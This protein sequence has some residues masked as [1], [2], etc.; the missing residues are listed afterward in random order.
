M[1]CRSDHL[2]TI[3]G[4]LFPALVAA[5]AISKANATEPRK[6][7]LMRCART[8]KGVSAA[9]NVVSLKL[10]V[11]DPDVVKKVNEHLSPQIRVWNIQVTNQGFNGHKAC[12]SRIYE[13]LIPTFSLLP[14]H[15]STY[16]GKKIAEYAEKEGDVEAHAARQEEVATYWKDV[17]ETYIKPIL[18]DTPEEIREIVE[19]ALWRSDNLEIVRAEE[20]GDQE[21]PQPTTTDESNPE[22]PRKP[23]LPPD[24]ARSHPRCDEILETI[25]K[26]KAAHLSAKRA[27]R[28]PSS[29]FNRFQSAL[30]KYVGTHNFFNY[31]IQ[32]RHDE[33]SSK[34]HIKSFN[35][36]P[37][38]VYVGGIEWLS[39]KVHGQS[40]MMH[41]IRKMVSMAVQVVRCGCDPVR[42]DESFGPTRIGIPKAP[43]LGLLL[44]RPIFD[45]FNKRIMKLGKEP[46]TF[47]KFEKDIDEFKHREIYTRIFKE[48][49]ES[50]P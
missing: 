24:V 3:E 42:I 45:G 12:D 27:Y 32:K 44:E 20:A 43:G 9:G 49:E 22:A 15:P 48:E 36:N 34:R 37:E 14:P 18:D 19:T 47:D 35:V 46:V 26:L 23:A 8:D 40:F 39:C 28:V 29:R 33:P 16:I 4:D 17:D 38:P 10:M 2:K 1:R 25:K 21:H 31:T 13:Y 7:S 41:Q 50:H 6:S 30:N 11:D 5:G